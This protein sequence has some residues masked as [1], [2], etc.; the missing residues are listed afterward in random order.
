MKKNKKFDKIFSIPNLILAAILLFFVVALLA[1]CGVKKSV[2]SDYRQSSEQRIEA[3]NAANERLQISAQTVERQRD[4]IVEVSNNWYTRYLWSEQTRKQ[5]S[6]QYFTTLLNI[7][8][9]TSKPTDSVTGKPP[10]SSETIKTTEKNTNSASQTLINYVSELEQ[11]YNRLQIDS[12]NE[13]NALLTTT[14]ERDSLAQA[15]NVAHSDSSAAQMD[16]RRGMSVYQSVMFWLG[17]IVAICMIATIIFCGI[18]I[19][20]KKR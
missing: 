20:V 4:S 15:L 6:E 3:L 9:D 12:H 13:H 19:Y 16:E 5:E 2:Y 1:S 10:V 17:Q 18:R 14:H 11:N 7:Q 8:Y